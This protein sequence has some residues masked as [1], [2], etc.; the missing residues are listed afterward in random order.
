MRNYLNGTRLYNEIQLRLRANGRKV[1]VVE[2]EEDYDLLYEHFG[3][4]RINFMAGYGKAVSLEAAQAAET[5]ADS[6]RF[7]IDADF[8]RITGDDA[9]W[10]SKVVAS[11]RYDLVA[12][13]SEINPRILT[14]IARKNSAEEHWASAEMHVA[15]ARRV[16]IAIGA[17]RLAS[18]IEGWELSMSNFPTAVVLP[19]SPNGPVDEEQLADMAIQRTH[20]CQVARQQVLAAAN[21]ERASLSDESLLIN[22]HDLLQALNRIGSQFAGGQANVSYT[23]LF[24]YVT[25]EA[26][27]RA[28]PSVLEIENWVTAA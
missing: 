5:D 28:V 26:E 12:D 20:A 9:S 14:K 16:A 4:A 23:D 10:G 7:Y 27:L 2:G 6:V 1:V 19:V 21:K 15:L 22:G 11:Q 13:V 8:D 17:T 3:E 18:R 24:T 25:T